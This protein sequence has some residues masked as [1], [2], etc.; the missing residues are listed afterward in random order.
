MIKR[1]LFTQFLFGKQMWK[2]WVSW[3][4]HK[5]L[6]YLG[7]VTEKVK[8]CHF[9]NQISFKLF[10][11]PRFSTRKGAENRTALVYHIIMGKEKAK[12]RH[13]FESKLNLFGT[14]YECR[15]KAKYI[16]IGYLK[17]YCGSKKINTIC[18]L[19]CIIT[20][21]E[22]VHCFRIWVFELFVNIRGLTN[23]KVFGSNKM[24]LI[25]LKK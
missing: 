1:A 9:K 6:T 24:L 17:R 15:K 3:I 22:S 18:T 2:N 11:I 14:C 10:A 20:H 8:V 7:K 12:E 19:I 23:Q 4:F 25:W 16:I 5:F 21:W 13:H